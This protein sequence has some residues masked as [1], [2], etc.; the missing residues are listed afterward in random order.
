M[1]CKSIGLFAWFLISA[2]PVC[3][4]PV[5]EAVALMPNAPSFSPVL[6]NLTYIYEEPLNRETEF[7]GSDFG[8][9]P[10]LK[11]RNDSFDI[12]ETMSVHCG[13]VKGPQPGR[14]TGFDI[15]EADLLEM[16]QCRGIVVASAVFDAFDDVKA[17]QNISKYAEETVCFYMFVDEETE[18]ILKRERGLDGNKKVGIWRVVVVHNLPYSDGRRNGKVN[19]PIFQIRKFMEDIMHEVSPN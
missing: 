18:S 12:K 9:Y 16:K 8:G 4:L 7:G 19:T 14:N 15:D 2:C 17:P 3:Y 5:E 10:T 13:F 6:K 1:F 11:H